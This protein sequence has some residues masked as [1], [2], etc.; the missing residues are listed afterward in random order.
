MWIYQPLLPGGAQQQAGGGGGAA[1]TRSVGKGLIES[2]LI[3]PRSLV[4]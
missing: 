4:K 3:S 2:P 1:P